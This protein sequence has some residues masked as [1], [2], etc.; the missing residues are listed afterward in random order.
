[1]NHLL[2]LLTDKRYPCGYLLQ[3]LLILV[4][5]DAPQAG[6]DQ[7]SACQNA[8]AN[9]VEQLITVLPA[10]ITAGQ[11]ALFKYQI[12]EQVTNK[13][14]LAF[15][16]GNRTVAINAVPGRNRVIA[17]LTQLQFAAQFTHYAIKRQAFLV[18]LV[19]KRPRGL[20]A[21]AS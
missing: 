17:R 14:A 8:V 1:M 19:K 5:T 13:E 7:Q 6:G 10:A 11:A 15:V 20:Q 18:P 16:A 3:I 4:V 2:T 9:P 21:T 12:A